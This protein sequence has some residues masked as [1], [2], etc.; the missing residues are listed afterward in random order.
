MVTTEL[1]EELERSVNT[2]PTIQSSSEAN[3]SNKNQD[4]LWT[5]CAGLI[6]S[7]VCMVLGHYFNPAI[8]ADQ[9]VANGIAF[10][11]EKYGSEWRTKVNWETLSIASPENCILGQLEGTYAAG[12]RKH[13][14]SFSWWFAYKHGFLPS[15]FASDADFSRLWRAKAM[16]P[17]M[18]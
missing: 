9:Q 17:A 1:P 7:C 15:A 12:L 14:S 16:L 5:I 2:Q 4:V 3:P 8:P 6:F 18:E 13:N 10:L 11:D